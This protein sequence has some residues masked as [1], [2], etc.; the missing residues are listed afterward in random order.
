MVLLQQVGPVRKVRP[1]GMPVKYFGDL[2]AGV[3]NMLKMDNVLSVDVHKL[4][5]YK[6]TLYQ[7]LFSR[8]RIYAEDIVYQFRTI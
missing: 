8:E 3:Y 6:C 5:H 2:R 7:S 4:R 1:A